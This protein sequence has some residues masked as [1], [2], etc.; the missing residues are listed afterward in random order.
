MKLIVHTDGGAR[1]NPGAAA[2]GVI[3][4]NETGKVIA[5]LGK[6]LGIRTNNQAEYG[7]V[8]GALEFIN[9]FFKQAG[10]ISAIEFYLDSDLIVN[11]LSGKYKIKSPEL[12]MLAIKA[13]NL[14]KKNFN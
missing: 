13:K 7:G 1:G 6:D 14:E 5:K 12:A 3:I 10:R 4:E 2:Y 8:I 11:Q 9:K